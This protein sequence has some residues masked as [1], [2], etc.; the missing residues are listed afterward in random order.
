MLILLKDDS[1]SRGP[2]LI[3][4]IRGLTDHIT[5]EVSDVNER[6][7]EAKNRYEAMMVELSTIVKLVTELGY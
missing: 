2:S 6:L 5:Q 3:V 4:M 7:T 1:K